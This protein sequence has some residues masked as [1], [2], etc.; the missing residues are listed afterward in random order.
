VGLISGV[1]VLATVLVVSAT[2][3]RTSL[4]AIQVEVGGDLRRIAQVAATTIDGDLHRTF[5]VRG[6]ETSPD[7]ERAV[8]PLSK[9]VDSS[10]E[11]AFVYT[12]VEDNGR[13]RFV[14]DPTPPGDADE[15]GV[16]DKSYI[17]QLYP[18][19]SQEAMEALQKKTPIAE[20]EPSSDE[21][22]TFISGFAPFYDSKGEFVGVV[23]VD[24]EA[25]DYAD[26]LAGVKKAALLALIV[27]TLL[28]LG[29]GFLAGLA[30]KVSLASHAEI[31]A[32]ERDL[33]SAKDS[34][35]ESMRSE[36]AAK[37]QVQAASQRFQ[38][39]FNEL[40]VGCF[41]FDADG[42]IHEWNDHVEDTFGLN[43]SDL[44]NRP[45]E[46][47]FGSY[48]E[49]I[50]TVTCGRSLHDFEWKYQRSDGL[51]LVLLTTAFA[52]EMGDR[53]VGGI[54]SILDITDRKVLERRV[55][56]QLDEANEL[57][58]L[59]DCQR[60]QLEE[61]NRRLEEL[62]ITDGLTGVRNRRSLD[63]EISRAFQVAER[64]GSKLSILLMDVDHFKQYNDKHGHIAG[65]DVLKS[66]AKL[67]T[68]GA[69]AYDVVAR[70][71]GEEFCV[72]LPATDLSESI[73]IGE[74]LRLAIQNHAWP[75]TPVTISVGAATWDFHTDRESL[76]GFADMALYRSKS[77][78]R[79]RVSHA[80]LPEGLAA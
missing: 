59:L 7:Y 8:A 47:V 50:A 2:Q 25:T 72:L 10:K 1:A 44:L 26:R 4:H 64:Q 65:D 28:S 13:A 36:L 70:Y 73:A 54:G 71:G 68:E 34:L 9:I 79:N 16:E 52:F 48:G 19:V 20:A 21:W 78:G 41:T 80:S 66:V 38:L 55:A 75:E 14:L 77:K 58:R 35:E 69:R 33:A 17:M 60:R 40:P 56:D 31:L 61:S 29:I 24:L 53:R 27:G 32:R 57:N 42:L 6:Q 37:E 51:E 43:A 67:L 22:G 49:T 15:D 39:L 76:L 63:D 12:L 5:Q 45:I 46:E 23:G 11:I 62:S 3:Y 18:E 30:Q 74:R